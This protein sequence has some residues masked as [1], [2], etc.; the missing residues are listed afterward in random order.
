LG[1]YIKAIEKTSNLGDL[2]LKILKIMLDTS[3]SRYD[4]LILSNLDQFYSLIKGVLK[5]AK[6]LGELKNPVTAQGVNLFS[7]TDWVGSI[8]YVA[9]FGLIA[10]LGIK[11]LQKADALT[12]ATLT[13]AN[14]KA[15]VAEEAVNGVT[16][17]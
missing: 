1:K 13:P 11:A 17:L 16:V 14:Y 10:V 9:W 2:R 4:R 5:M 6:K 15:A 8:L 7:V 3:L 12:P